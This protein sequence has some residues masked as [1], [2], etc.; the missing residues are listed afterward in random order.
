M[1]TYNINI[2][3]LKFKK[4]LERRNEA[5][6]EGDLAMN[7]KACT[8]TL[9]SFDLLQCNIQAVLQDWDDEED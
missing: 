7:Q 6:Q 3:K 1:T 5:Y 2:N 9:K 4:K 8:H